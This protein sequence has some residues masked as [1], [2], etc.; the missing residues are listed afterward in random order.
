[1]DTARIKALAVLGYNFN[2]HLLK[3][4]LP[5]EKKDQAELFRSYFKDDRIAPFTAAE[6]AELNG[7]ETCVACGLCPSH[8]RVM[9]L[10]EGKF[11]GPMHLAVAASRSQPEFMHDGDSL[12]LCAACGQCEPVCPERVPV[13]RMARAMRA[14]LWRTAPEAL[15]EAYHHAAENLKRHGSIYGEP[16]AGAAPEH[17]DA[18][19]ALV[20]GPSLKRDAG[21]AGRVAE[22]LKKLGIDVTCIN[23]GSIGGVAESLG[24]VPDTGW[25]DALA[26]SAA[27]TVIVA[28]PDEWI[29]LKD[30]LR[31]KGK[32]V[33]FILEAVAEKM[34]AGLTLAS[35]ING[36]AAVHDTHA[37]CRRSSMWKL[38]RDVLGRA[39]VG[40]VEMEKHGEWSPPLGWEG[41]IELALPGL[42]GLL[43]R[44]RLDDAA[45]AGALSLIV[46]SAADAALLERAGVD[47]EV[48][49]HYF[50]DMV[51]EAL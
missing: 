44:A 29:A 27:R 4:V 37:L 49:V 7:F 50:L 16:A 10:S 33:K 51:H 45:R 21:R 35:L 14:M 18:G 13:G 43:A 20:L 25:V 32:A 22:A 41:G 6:T 47:H 19:A 48:S 42:A 3:K 9:E 23:E 8:C 11:L 5:H 28:E 36:R 46:F 1:M 38:S 24:L 40:I 34:P 2:L 12:F 30:D 26:A 31:L 15:P 17:R 39:G